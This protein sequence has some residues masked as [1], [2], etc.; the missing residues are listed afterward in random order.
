M[1][2]LNK[3]LNYNVLNSLKYKIVPFNEEGHTPLNLD[4][5]HCRTICT[6]VDF[7]N[8]IKVHNYP[9]IIVHSN[10]IKNL[11]PNHTYLL[12]P[13]YPN[14]DELL[15]QLREKQIPPKKKGFF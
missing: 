11:N 6:N 7:K 1:S 5:I 2:A 10:Q 15:H 9:A 8:F 13:Y 3:R 12:S 14:R 4:F